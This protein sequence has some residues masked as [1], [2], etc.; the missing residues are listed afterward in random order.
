MTNISQSDGLIV[1]DF[2][3]FL[4]LLEAN[5]GKALTQKDIVYIDTWLNQY[6]LSQEL[7]IFMYGYANK[8]NIKNVN[9]ID[10]IAKDW[11]ENNVLTV[12][13]AE[14]YMQKKSTVQNVIKK[15]LGIKD[16]NLIASELDYIRKWQHDYK[17]SIEIIVEACNRT[18][19]SI[20][21]P[22]FRYI[23]AILA[24]WYENNVRSFHDINL[25]DARHNN[26]NVSVKS[27]SKN[28]KFHNFSQRDYDF[29]LLERKLLNRK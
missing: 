4:L 28:K 16:R 15:A 20:N 9:Y 8:R 6:N 13:A 2:E 21:K 26:K 14:E 27:G 29:D 23:D 11:H 22:S 1:D 25:L 3:T 10:A 17:F 24:N 18:I 7:I 5:I 19:T 12:R